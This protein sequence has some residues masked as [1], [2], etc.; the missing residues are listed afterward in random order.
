MDA[1]CSSPVTGLFPTH[2]Q[3]QQVFIGS[4]IAPGSCITPCHITFVTTLVVSN[5]KSR[6]KCTHHAMPAQ[7]TFAAAAAAG[8]GGGGGRGREGGQWGLA[9]ARDDMAV[10]CTMTWRSNK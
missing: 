6:R 10:R 5:M 7:K 4:D 3:L 1:R 8:G 9:S 2:M